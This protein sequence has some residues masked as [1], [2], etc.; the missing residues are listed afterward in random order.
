MNTASLVSCLVR[1]ALYSIQFGAVL[2]VV[3]RV[4]DALGAKGA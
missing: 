4:L 1:D 2:D 3:T